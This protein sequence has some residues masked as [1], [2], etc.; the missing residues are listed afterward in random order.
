MSE[1]SVEFHL[2]RYDTA[3]HLVFWE[4]TKACGLACRHCRASA[5]TE[6][7]PGELTFDEGCRLLDRI[8]SW[9]TP[10]PLVILTGGDCLRRRDLDELVAYGRERHIRFALSPSVTDELSP[11]RLAGLF[12]QGIRSVS[13]SLD[14]D[15]PAT[16][17]AI[18]GITGHFER[19]LA[20]LDT[21]SAM[22]FRVQVNTTVMRKNASELARIA[23]LLDQHQI[24]TWEVFFLIGV[25]R[26]AELDEVTPDIAEDVCHFLVDVTER[27]TTVRTVEAPFFRRVQAERRAAPSRGDE[28]A[29]TSPFYASLR[30]ELLRFPAPERPETASHS[31]ATGDGRGII[32]VGHDGEVYASGFLP[33]SLGNV[34]HDDLTE[35]YQR[36]PDLVRMRRGDLEGECGRCPERQLC[37]GSRARA[38]ARFGRV[39]AEDPACSHTE[40]ARRRRLA[41][42]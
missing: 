31:L 23:H 30:T 19:T 9:S 20:A 28:R 13:I 37:G 10:S 34:R 5:Q 3:P 8:A 17:D 18:R 33:V 42:V 4:T 27:G 16:H 7:A 26:G 40:W 15:N 1:R 39:T 29:A 24:R 2:A 36:H 25:G 21:L 38:F 41:L 12:A 32:F 14:G 22:G 6:P 11:E 35:I